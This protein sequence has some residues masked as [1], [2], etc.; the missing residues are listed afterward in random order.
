[1]IQ[2]IVRAETPASAAVPVRA[3]TRSLS[4]P[5]PGADRARMS[6]IARPMAPAAAA[7]IPPAPMARRTR[8]SGSAARAGVMSEPAGSV[9]SVSGDLGGDLLDDG[10]RLVAGHAGVQPLVVENGEH[11]L[12][13]GGQKREFLVVVEDRG[14]G[15]GAVV[16]KTQPLRDF[17]VKTGEAQKVGVLAANHGDRAGIDAVAP[18]SDGQDETVARARQ[19]GDGIH[20]AVGNRGDKLAQAWLERAA[21]VLVDDEDVEIPASLDRADRVTGRDGKPAGEGAD[22][23]GVLQLLHR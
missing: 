5:N 12:V 13:L 14:S 4:K 21:L 2:S 23:V 15:E 19:G 22:R 18:G 17:L 20:R 8:S 11:R 9:S 7:D 6:A 1:M 10:G 3:G 16:R